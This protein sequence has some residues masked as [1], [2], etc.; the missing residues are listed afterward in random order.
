MSSRNI[1]AWPLVFLLTACASDADDSQFAK[2]DDRGGAKAPFN[3]DARND[4]DIEDDLDV[5]HIP[6]GSDGA[7]LFRFSDG[8]AWASDEI[9]NDTDWDLAFIGWDIRTNGGASG[10]GKGSAMGPFEPGVYLNDSWPNVPF[11]FVDRIGGAFGDWY[12]YDSAGGNVLYSRYHVYAVRRG[13]DLWKVQILG[14]YG[15]IA[16]APVS[17]L[18][19]LRY[20]RLA[21]IAGET[22]TVTQIDATASGAGGL[23]AA[24][25]DCLDLASGKRLSLTPVEAAASSDWH[26][27]FR[28]DSIT[29]NGEL[30]GP[31][32]VGA[33]DLDAAAVES[34]TLAE[35]KSRTAESELAR[36]ET[37]DAAAFAGLAL[38]G[39]R[40]VSAFDGD[41]VDQSSSPPVPTQSAWAVIGADGQSRWLMQF[42]GFD[43]PTAD[44]PGIVKARMKRV[45]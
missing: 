38:R 37:V 39:D 27:C 29:V 9:P 2:P 41:W 15:D 1:L 23:D 42:V 40:I 26:L 45:Q 13:D 7:T 33:V 5:I 30:G 19:S 3:S 22:V 24:P 6:V 10:P 14:Y 44:S 12:F 32:N 31:G 17:A 18:Y 34:E 4:D 8:N 25:S 36:F 28:R 43:E 35:I 16:G 11:T 20:A 21:P